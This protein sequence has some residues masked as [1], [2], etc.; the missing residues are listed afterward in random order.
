MCFFTDIYYMYVNKKKF[1][2]CLL[3]S[4]GVGKGTAD[5]FKME[6]SQVGFSAHQTRNKV[7]ALYVCVFPSV[8][9]MFVCFFSWWFTLSLGYRIW[10][11][12]EQL[13]HI[14]GSGLLFTKLLRN[15]TFCP[16]LLLRKS[17]KIETIVHYLVS[18][19][20]AV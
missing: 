9:T 18:T 7:P 4:L 8:F 5:N 1:C 17:W 12:W 14:I 3:M 20:P 10:S 15:Q 13:V 6:M 2:F 19:V 11:Y 16:K